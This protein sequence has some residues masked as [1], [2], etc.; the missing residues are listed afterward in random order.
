MRFMKSR[1]GLDILIHAFPF[2]TPA[3]P[4]H[5]FSDHRHAVNFVRYLFSRSK[6]HPANEDT[7]LNLVCEMD[8]TG[9]ATARQFNTDPDHQLRD[10]I[11]RRMPA[12]NAEREFCDDGCYAIFAVRLPDGRALSNFLVSD[13]A[14]GRA[15]MNHPVF[16]K[17]TQSAIS[18]IT[19]DS[20]AFLKGGPV[21]DFEDASDIGMVYRVDGLVQG[22]LTRLMGYERE[23]VLPVSHR[24]QRDHNQVYHLHRLLQV[25]EESPEPF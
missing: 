21:A 16:H 20:T 5:T 2:G 24:D 6:S 19:R 9:R 1:N 12:R 17:L 15:S 8:G 11:Q 23:V 4:V 18:R 22:V 25:R 14:T 10:F 13:E 7:R 3:G